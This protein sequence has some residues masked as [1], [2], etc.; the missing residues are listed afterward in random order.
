MSDKRPVAFQGASGSNSDIAAR[1]LFRDRETLPCVTFDEAFE[2]VEDGRAECAVIPIDNS[3]AGRVADIHT[4]LPH[5]STHIVGEYFQPIEHTF[6]GVPGS[7]LETVRTVR[8]HVHALA[9]CRMFIQKHGYAAEVDYDTAGAA[10]KVAEATDISVA[11]IAPPLAGE[12]YGLISLATDIADKRENVTRFL[13]L[14]QKRK[15]PAIDDGPFITSIYFKL[16]SVPAALYKAIS[17]FATNGINLIKLE[18]YLG[19]GFQ[20]AEFYIE[21]EGHPDERLMK[22]AL[23][24]MRFFTEEVRILGTYP[25][26]SYR[27]N[28]EQ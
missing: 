13:L 24:E 14:S 6:F 12:L 5:R 27:Q 8:S 9:Q 3:I 25:K 22:L 11:A 10:H 16:R 15:L 21:A 18:S 20:T 28:L 7:T 4:L 26:H 2:A 1:A 19:E 17:G 23:D